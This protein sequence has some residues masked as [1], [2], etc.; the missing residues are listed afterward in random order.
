M[1]IVSYTV[2][3]ATW[4]DGVVVVDGAGGAT[5]RELAGH[6][7]RWLTGAPD[8]QGG[9]LAIFNGHAVMRRASGGLWSVV[10]EAELDL[11]C[12]VGTRDAIYVGTDDA[13]VL[14]VD[15]RGVIERLDGFDKVPGRE[16]WYAGTAVIDGKVVG[17]PLGVRSISASLDGAL[18]LANVHVGG[19]PRSV[20]RGASWAPT[21]DVKND[22]HEVRV[23]PERAEIVAAASGAGL[24]FSRDGGATWKVEQ[25]G[26]HALHCSAVGFAGRD[27]LISAAVQQ[28]AAQGAV[29][30]RGID[31]D[32]PLVRV[33]G[34]LPEWLAGV[35]D[36]GC[37]ASRGAVVAL[38]DRGGN[39]YVSEDG[40]GTWK[41][42][43][44]GIAMASNVLVV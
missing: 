23:H 39:L 11:S 27:V 5:S 32:G 6:A 34:G 24:C 43:A 25:R 3:V 28:F 14:R 13:S 36:T 19:I 37:I 18:L 7:V 4:D 17:P 10:A 22:V 33:G 40:G 26:L 38:A 9:V 30:R 8:W 29:Y 12:C 20:D 35:V 42:R 21:V 15:E 1:D 44:D 16:S 41:L 2:L 31:D